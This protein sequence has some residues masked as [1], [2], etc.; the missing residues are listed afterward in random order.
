M[1]IATILWAANILPSKDANGKQLI[2]DSLVTVNLGVVSRPLPF[3]F[4]M[5]PRFPEVT[6]IIAQT[7]ELI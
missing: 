6:A 3:E 4:S 5:T 1:N 2:P 7:K